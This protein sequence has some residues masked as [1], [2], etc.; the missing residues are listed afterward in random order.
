MLDEGSAVQGRDGE[1]TT[2]AGG[3]VGETTI[4]LCSFCNCTFDH[5][6][7]CENHMK[8]VS[9]QYQSPSFTRLSVSEVQWLSGFLYSSSL[10]VPPVS[11][12]L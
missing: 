7:E 10:R 8:M 3:D 6:G 2:M 12:T 1:A 5:F 4:Y 11:L 9:C